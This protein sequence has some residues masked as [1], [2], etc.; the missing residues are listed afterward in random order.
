MEILGISRPTLSRWRRSGLVPP[1][2]RIAGRAP[3][4]VRSDIDFLAGVLDQ[5][6][7]QGV[8]TQALKAP[9]YPWRTNRLPSLVGLTDAAEMLGVSRAQMYRW[10]EPGS[11][12]RGARMTF[13]VPPREV[14]DVVL[15]TTSDIERFRVESKAML[16]TKG[17]AESPNWSARQRPSRVRPLRETYLHDLIGRPDVA[18]ML[19]VSEAQVDAWLKPDTGTYG[20]DNTYIVTPRWVNGQPVWTKADIERFRRVLA[21]VADP[22]AAAD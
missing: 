19:S 18:D 15:W 12:N 21:T 9:S 11:G 2:P 7:S 22:L 13:L 4:W 20:P 17:D 1:V 6:R 16:D 14:E 5:Q 10:L 3:I 8:S